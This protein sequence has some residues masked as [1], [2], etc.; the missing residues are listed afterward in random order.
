VLACTVAKPWAEAH[1]EVAE[2][3][4]TEVQGYDA[5]ELRCK[6]SGGLATRKKDEIATAL[7]QA[8]ME[9]TLRCLQRS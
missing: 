3:D 5:Q 4:P 1:S 9:S 8:Q 2:E 6:H 7:G